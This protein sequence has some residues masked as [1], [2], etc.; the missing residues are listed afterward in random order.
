MGERAESWP[1]L[2]SVMKDRK[3]NCSKHT[4]FSYQ[5]NNWRRK[6]RFLNQIQL[7]SKLLGEND[8][9]VVGKIEW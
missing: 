4:V 6:R 3:K 2:I 5:L 7:C 1:I 8:N 9:W